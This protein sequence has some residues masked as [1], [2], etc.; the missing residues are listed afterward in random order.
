MDEGC[1]D[2]GHQGLGGVLSSLASAVRNAIAISPLSSS[3]VWI[4]HLCCLFVVMTFGCGRGPEG[5]GTTEWPENREREKKTCRSHRKRKK[6][7]RSSS[8]TLKILLNVDR[9]PRRRAIDLRLVQTGYI[10]ET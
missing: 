10:F 8:F 6:Q 3:S 1:L 4:E 7:Q 2:G 9:F 5:D